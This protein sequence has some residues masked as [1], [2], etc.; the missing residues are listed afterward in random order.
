MTEEMKW[1]IYIFD[2]STQDISRWD[3]WEPGSI[4]AA[5]PGFRVIELHPDRPA[6]VITFDGIIEDPDAEAKAESAKKW[7]L[8]DEG[9]KPL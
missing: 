3:F 5:D 6:R 7:V 4:I 9:L 8:T 1:P 2:E